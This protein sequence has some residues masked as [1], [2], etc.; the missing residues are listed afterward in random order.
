[1]A[2]RKRSRI[3]KPPKSDTDSNQPMIFAIH[4]ITAPYSHQSALTAL[5]FC[6]ATLAAG[7]RIKRVFFSGD[8]VLVGTRLAVPPQDE[9]DLYREWQVLA[10]THQVEL[11]VCISA[12]LRRGII[13][14][15][16]AERYEKS[17][18]NLAEGFLLS[19]LGQLVEAGLESD[20]LVTFGA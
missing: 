14:A 7:H 6:Q 16:E 5:R 2:E 1:M 12:C 19:G 8:G 11:V 4:V 9:A 3:R 15:S 18:H 17:S 13:N 20:R 10:N